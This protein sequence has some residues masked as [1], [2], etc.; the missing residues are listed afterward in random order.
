MWKVKLYKDYLST[1]TNNI[2]K[3]IAKLYKRLK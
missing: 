3:K 2:K 1:G